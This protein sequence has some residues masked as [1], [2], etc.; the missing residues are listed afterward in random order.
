MTN[1]HQS[2]PPTA[3]RWFKIS[4]KK[5][6]DSEKKT[7]RPSPNKNALRDL[8]ERT[9]QM[10]LHQHDA[11]ILVPVTLALQ[12]HVGLLQF[13]LHAVESWMAP[14]WY[15]FISS[16]SSDRNPNTT[17][18]KTETSILFHQRDNGPK[19]PGLASLVPSNELYDRLMSNRY[20]C[21]S[22]VTKRPWTW[23]QISA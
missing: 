14:C 11:A 15:N 5:S 22:P 21:L 23:K 7:R 13:M 20:Y 8:W 16:E 10:V 3:P 6:L 17:D 2:C 12:T 9:T 4:K 1:L 19:Y 18:D